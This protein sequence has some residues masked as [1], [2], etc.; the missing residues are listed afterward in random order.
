VR[1]DIGAEHVLDRLAVGR[2]VPGDAFQRV[3]S[4]D[5]DVSVRAAQ[6][7]DCTAEPVGELPFPADMDLAPGGDGA[8]H[9]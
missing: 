4:T 7:I 5:A 6:L 8:D 2:R 3:E 1:A 9:D